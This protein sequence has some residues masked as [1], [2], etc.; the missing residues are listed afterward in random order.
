MNTKLFSIVILL[1]GFVEQ[2]KAQ[3]YLDFDYYAEYD[4]HGVSVD[5]LPTAVFTYYGVFQSLNLHNT[6]SLGSSIYEVYPDGGVT[7]F[8]GEPVVNTFLAYSDSATKTVRL[9]TFDFEDSLYSKFA[10]LY[11]YSQEIGDTLHSD[12]MN[13]N[14]S[15]QHIITAIDTINYNGVDRRTFSISGTFGMKIIQG[16]GNTYGF[17]TTDIT[18]FEGGRTLDCAFFDGFHAY[19]TTCDMNVGEMNNG[20]LSIYPNPSSGILKVE[21]KL[22]E[23]RNSQIQVKDIMGRIVFE[24]DAQQDLEILDLSFLPNGIYVIHLF[25]DNELI[26][27]KKVILKK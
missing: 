13:P 18:P 20:G 8:P 24:K 19:G 21:S 17:I 10:V 3:D 22:V 6:D 7:I 23:S 1:L 14:N 27:S 15:G 12:I 26:D 16:I 25:N 5:F 11:D 9:T 2:L 4:I